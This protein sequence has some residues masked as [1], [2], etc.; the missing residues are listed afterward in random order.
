MIYIVIGISFILIWLITT[1]FIVRYVK[2]LKNDLLKKLSDTEKPSEGKSEY[3]P[4]EDERINFKPF[5]FIKRVDLEH[6][7]YFLQQEHT[8]VIALVLA[9]MEPDKASVILQN[10]PYAIQGEVS[11]RVATMGAVNP[12]VTREI[13]RIMEKKL[14]SLSSENYFAPGGIENIAKIINKAN[15][16]SKKQ[17]LKALEEENQDITVEIKN[18]LKELKNPY[19]RICKIFKKI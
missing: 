2:T 6:F 3:L 16:D 4:N 5:D 19:K 1:F 10:L 18:R 14:F 17:I 7:S 12:E 13:G 11:L 9:Y 15:R 8:Q